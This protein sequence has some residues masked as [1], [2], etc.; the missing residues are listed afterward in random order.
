MPEGLFQREAWAQRVLRES[1]READAITACSEQTLTEAEEWFGESLRA[2]GQ[3]VHNGVAAHEAMAVPYSHPNPYILAIGRH[4]PQKGFDVLLRALAVLT[5]ANLPKFDLILAG[6]GPE[7]PALR[8]LAA[9]L[10]VAERVHFPGRVEHDEALR[11]FAGSLFFVLPS[12]KEPF[13]LVNLEAMMTGKAVIASRVGGVPEIVNDKQ[14]GLLVPP[15]DPAALARAIAQLMT[16]VPLRRKLGLAGR[17]RAKCF[18]WA[19]AVDRYFS[20]Y[21]TLPERCSSE[22]AT[23]EQRRAA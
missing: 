9:E 23:F 16:N 21:Q 3:V 5:G 17:E 12:R 13:G 4:V 10:G 1:L 22:P 6:D 7:H 14:N 8:A 2:K 15:E 18:T 19:R 20:V 11:L